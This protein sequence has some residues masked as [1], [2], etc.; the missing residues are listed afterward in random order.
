MH[1]QTDVKQNV[2]FDLLHEPIWELMY[3]IS[4][5]VFAGKDSF[6]R[7]RL[8]FFIK[9]LKL[10]HLFKFFGKKAGTWSLNYKR[11]S[12]NKKVNLNI[13]SSFSFDPYIDRILSC[14]SCS[15]CAYSAPVGS[16]TR[17]AILVAINNSGGTR[18]KKF[19]TGQTDCRMLRKHTN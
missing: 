17:S 19:R 15:V 4:L 18:V 7:I 1:R 16:L 8:T 2:M 6:I 3:R 9:R 14:S 12:Q 10:C 11:K 13:S 5:A